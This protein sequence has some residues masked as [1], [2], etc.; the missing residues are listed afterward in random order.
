MCFYV[1]FHTQELLKCCV[2]KCVDQLSPTEPLSG[3]KD[4]G[5]K[6][7][8]KADK[9]NP[10]VGSIQAVFRYNSVLMHV[11]WIV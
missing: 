5:K 1:Y 2:A 6:K 9:M 4:G 3:H 11:L 8:A 7:K 10:V